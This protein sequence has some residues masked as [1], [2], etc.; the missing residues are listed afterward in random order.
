MAR[1]ESRQSL[2]LV[3]VVAV[4]GLTACG[5]HPAQSA[6]ALSEVALLAD[7]FTNALL[8][9]PIAVDAAG[10]V[11]VVDNGDHTIK[12]YDAD[13]RFLAVRGRGGAGPGELGSGVGIAV[14][15]EEVAVLDTRLQR[16]LLM[17]TSGAREAAV[18]TVSEGTMTLGAAGDDH[19]LLANSPT[20]SIADATAEAP[21]FT[22]HELDGDS[23]VRIGGREASDN[24]FADHIV[25][26]VLL[27]GTP[28]G[29]AIWV[30]RLNDPGVDLL[31]SDGR[32]IRRFERT[33]PFDW[34]RLPAAYRPTAALA[35]E[36]DAELPFDPISLGIAT[37]AAGNA[38]VLTA[39]GRAQGEEG[40]PVVVDVLSRTEG[41]QQRFRLPTSATHV[42]VSPDGTRIYVVDE[43]SAA[44][45]AYR[46]P[47]T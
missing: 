14:V 25:N 11:H 46:L 45:R 36:T 6:P 30:A 33:L 20:W 32:R 7:A 34:R 16:L 3:A 41:T 43:R 8:P 26:F 12:T 38:Y 13:G 9:G 5:A 44:I 4:A 42:A 22:I 18:A 40:P 35:A 27:A 31:S 2:F 10:R 39:V 47:A 17:P 19:Y 1:I 37:D 23:V 15:G 28:D 21:L 29:A 24:P